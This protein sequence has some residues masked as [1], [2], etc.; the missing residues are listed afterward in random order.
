MAVIAIVLYTLVGS[1]PLLGVVVAIGPVRLELIA[2]LLR[3]ASP[4][5][6]GLVLCGFLVKTPVYLLHAW[7]PK[8]HVEAPTRGSMFLARIL[9]K[10]GTYG[11]LRFRG[12][13]RIIISALCLTGYF[14]VST[15]TL[16][17]ILPSY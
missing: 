16:F 1:T 9:L 2:W 7:L 14:M 10:L 6:F 8:A 15:I 13:R 5:L 3:D 12:G 17:S 11:L 4:L